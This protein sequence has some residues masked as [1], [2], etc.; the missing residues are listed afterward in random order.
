MNNSSVD[1]KR[2]I[3]KPVAIA[4][5]LITVGL[6][7]GLSNLFGLVSTKHESDII[8]SDQIPLYVTKADAG[9]YGAATDL[10]LYYKATGQP[11]YALHWLQLAAN[12][13]GESPNEW[14]LDLLEKSSDKKRQEEAMALLR[15]LA[16]EGRAPFQVKLG[17]EILH[18]EHTNSD[19]K[20]A[21]YYFLSAAEQGYKPAILRYAEGLA[22]DISTLEDAINAMAWIKVARLCSGDSHNKELDLSEGLVVGSIVSISIQSKKDDIDELSKEIY[23]SIRNYVKNHKEMDFRYCGIER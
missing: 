21:N 9:D 19:T 6:I 14:L 15:K 16:N 13:G 2:K 17:E 18:G 10:Y 12:G 23:S 8:K 20:L 11:E 7:C 1:W 3:T 5:I 22:G 4:A